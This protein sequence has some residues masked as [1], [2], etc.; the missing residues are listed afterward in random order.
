K[1]A[2]PQA[3]YL[4]NRLPLPHGR[5]PAIHIV[6]GKEE[7]CPDICGNTAKA[8]SEKSFAPVCRRLGKKFHR[9]GRFKCRSTTAELRGA[10]GFGGTLRKIVFRFDFAPDWLVRSDIPCLS[11]GGS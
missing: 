6:E 9:A 2:D 1:P 4:A 5:T 10:N 3:S 8:N 7:L 11:I